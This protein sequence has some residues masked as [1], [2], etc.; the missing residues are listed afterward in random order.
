MELKEFALLLSGKDTNVA[1]NT[2]SYLIGNGIH[3]KEWGIALANLYYSF[4]E[5]IKNK[6]IFKPIILKYFSCYKLDK[7]NEPLFKEY[8]SVFNNNEL[9]NI[10]KLNPDWPFSEIIFKNILE[11]SKSLA[12]TKRQNVKE[13]FETYNSSIVKLIKNDKDKEKLIKNLDS[14]HFFHQLSIENIKEF[15]DLLETNFSKILFETGYFKTYG[16]VYLNLKDS[17]IDLF[18]S[19]IN[20]YGLDNVKK[21]KCFNFNH[22]PYE[23]D[24]RNVFY[25]FMSLIQNKQFIAAKKIFSFYEKDFIMFAN[26]E[27]IKTLNTIDDWQSLI[28]K[29]TNGYSSSYFP[30]PKQIPNLLKS[31]T[32]TEWAKELSNF[33]FCD[34]L[35]VPTEKKRGFKL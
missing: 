24:D 5:G 34:L 25:V 32:S 31:K 30:D 9:A 4:D 23:N 6:N 21:N 12:V 17:N 22:I 2:L 35:E 18:F 7:D 14:K 20:E 8:E 3:N 16:L 11:L 1:K 29:F 26:K 10:K 27:D 13:F 15:S 28:A 33:V 19:A